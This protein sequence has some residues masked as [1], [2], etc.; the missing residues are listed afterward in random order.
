MQVTLLAGAGLQAHTDAQVCTW[1]L[2]DARG[3]MPCSWVGVQTCS[4]AHIN[5]KCDL[6]FRIGLQ[7]DALSD[8]GIQMSLKEQMSSCWHPR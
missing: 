6:Q 5:G 4:P 3:H 2:H 8:C 1:L 7:Q